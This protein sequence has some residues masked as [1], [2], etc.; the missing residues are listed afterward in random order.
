[1]KPRPLSPRSLPWRPWVL[2]TLWCLLDPALAPWTMSAPWALS[3]GPFLWAFGAL[4][5]LLGWLMFR[6]YGLAALVLSLLCVFL[7]LLGLAE[8][9]FSQT[10]VLPTLAQLADPWRHP[11]QDAYALLLSW[12][13]GWC[14]GFLLILWVG[15]LATG[16]FS[17]GNP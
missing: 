4:A 15:H 14:I 5:I 16:R 13:Q 3:Q 11:S 7:A 9:V 1:M 6:R 12:V 2:W 8:L 17:P 10:V